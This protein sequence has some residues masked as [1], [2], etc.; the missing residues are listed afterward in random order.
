MIGNLI[1]GDQVLIIAEVSQT[2]DGS[3]GQAH[4]FVDAVAR[5]GAN[6]IK[7]QTHIA[8]AESTPAEPFRVPF[9]FQ[10]ASRYDYWKRMEFSPA[11]W[12]E[13]KRHAEDKGLLF[14]SSA[15]SLEACRLLE[16]IGIRAWKVGSGEVGSL[17]MLDWMAAT[18]KPIFISTGMGTYQEID[19]LVAHMRGLKADFALLQCT[20]AYPTPFEQVGL[21]VIDELKRRY[22]CPVGL[23]DHSGTI[24]PSIAA[25]MLGIELL[26]VHITLSRDMFGPDV[27]SSV[28]VDEFKQL[29]D[30]VRAVE[31]MRKHPVDKDGLSRSLSQMARTFGKSAVAIDNLISGTSIAAAHVTF[32]KPGGGIPEIEFQKYFG[33]TLCRE[34]LRDQPFMPEDFQS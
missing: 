30:G 13:L 34:V 8:A 4:A 31:V 33:R 17:S 16:G 12:A 28:T 5:T 21:N 15:F 26:E 3:L 10:D 18:G 7:F 2:H 22:A 9:S 32:K 23:S 6:A 11:Q 27:K 14:L 24:Y 19:S 1:S 29:A 20:T 25:T